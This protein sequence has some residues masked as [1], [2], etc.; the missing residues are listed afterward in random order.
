VV[1]GFDETRKQILIYSLVLAPV[2]MLPVWFGYAGYVYGV[3]AL[4][5]GAG[6]VALSWRVFQRVVRGEQRASEA[7]G[8]AAAPLRVLRA[9][10]T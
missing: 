7:R 9:L 2:G 1:S 10:G 3:I 6:M 5:C 8:L 4:L